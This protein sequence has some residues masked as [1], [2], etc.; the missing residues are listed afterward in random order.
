MSDRVRWHSDRCAQA[1][2]GLRAPIDTEGVTPVAR[3]KTKHLPYEKPSPFDADG[4]EGAD[5]LPR[6]LGAAP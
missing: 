4:A 2:G 3:F 1:S 5:V 6:S